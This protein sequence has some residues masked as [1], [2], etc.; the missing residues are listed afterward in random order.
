M[1]SGNGELVTW[2]IRDKSMGIH[3]HVKPPE[4][5]L[6]H[7]KDKDM[8][9]A[10]MDL[11]ED[12]TV[13]IENGK[14][15]LM[16]HVQESHVEVVERLLQDPRVLATINATVNH[17]EGELTALHFVCLAHGAPYPPGPHEVRLVRIIELPPPSRS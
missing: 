16:R 10:L 15:L 13:R 7:A 6:H 11:G 4:N 8:V 17:T 2:L 14:T 3:G 9:A 12:P 1:E 5:L